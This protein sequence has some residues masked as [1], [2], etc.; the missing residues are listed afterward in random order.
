MVRHSPLAG[1][2]QSLMRCEAF[3]LQKFK[4]AV[5]FQA[6]ALHSKVKLSPIGCLCFSH[7]QG[8][9]KESVGTGQGRGCRIPAV[10][11]NQ[12]RASGAA[13]RAISEASAAK[14]SVS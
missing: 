7:M 5:L 8:T 9:A 6:L 2:M 12:F 4:R 3:S 1:R 11:C 14:C 10:A 13:A